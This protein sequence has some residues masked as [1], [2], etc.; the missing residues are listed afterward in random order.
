M[1][2]PSGG[3]TSSS[4]LSW[5]VMSRGLTNSHFPISLPLLHRRRQ[6][7][8]GS[9]RSLGGEGVDLGRRS[10]GTGEVDPAALRP[11]Y[12]VMGDRSG[13]V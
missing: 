4:A 6:L 7:R 11:E 9:G 8:G 12:V 2:G 10:P 5:V 13:K 1:P 3:P